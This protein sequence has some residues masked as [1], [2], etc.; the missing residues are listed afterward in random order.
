MSFRQVVTL[1][2]AVA[3]TLTNSRD[4]SAHKHLATPLILRRKSICPPRPCQ[5]VALRTKSADHSKDA[6]RSSDRLRGIEGRYNKMI[7]QLYSGRAGTQLVD[8]SQPDRVSA[9]AFW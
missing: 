7:Y 6:R 9:M 4:A 8:S 1:T 5:T 2:C 3:G